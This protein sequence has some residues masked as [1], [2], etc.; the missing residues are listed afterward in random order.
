[1][2]KLQRRDCPSG[3][4]LM[5]CALTYS[6]VRAVILHRPASD[7]MGRGKDRRD[8]RRPD[9]KTRIQPL[10]SLQHVEDDGHTVVNAPEQ[11]IRY[12]G[13]DRK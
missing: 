5:H 2:S 13:Y 4:G 12:R 11:C 3:T 6:L 1:M 9:I 8:V 10:F 7:Q